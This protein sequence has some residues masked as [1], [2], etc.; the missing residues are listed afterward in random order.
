MREKYFIDVGM[1]LSS[2]KAMD[3]GECA[4]DEICRCPYA[5]SC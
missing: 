3:R 1:I 4:S 5:S 2:Y